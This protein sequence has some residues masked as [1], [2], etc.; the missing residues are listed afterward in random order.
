MFSN[1]RSYLSRF[2]STILFIAALLVIGIL[3][4]LTINSADD[5]SENGAVESETATTST[6]STTSNLTYDQVEITDTDT[7]ATVTVESNTAS[8]STSYNTSD[9]QTLAVTEVSLDSEDSVVIDTGTTNSVG[10]VDAE[11]ESI[12]VTGVLPDTGPREVITVALS[13]FIITLALV[14]WA[15][16][17]QNLSRQLLIHNR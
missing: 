16:S 4:I 11:G 17:R 10:R 6:S 5:N 8:S 2:S 12:T 9:P 13:F 14:Y 15:R 3:I 7:G 1:A